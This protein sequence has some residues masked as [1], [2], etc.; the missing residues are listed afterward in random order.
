MHFRSERDMEVEIKLLKQQLNEIKL[1]SMEGDNSTMLERMKKISDVA[2]QALSN[3]VFLKE[4]DKIK[5]R[6]KG[7]LEKTDEDESIEDT[8][9]NC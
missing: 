5:M 4:K 8:K 9:E 7:H 1:I 2:N 6:P 3:K